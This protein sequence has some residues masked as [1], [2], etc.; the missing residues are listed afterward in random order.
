MQITNLMTNYKL[1]NINFKALD[2]KSEQNIRKDISH[3]DVKT[4]IAI[5]KLIE[6][7]NKN[8]Y[9]TIKL[10]SAKQG[11]NVYGEPVSYRTAMASSNL[12]ND[13]YITTINC[14]NPKGFSNL[15]MKIDYI[16]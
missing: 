6:K 2:S 8:Q 3:F 5:E 4:R 11:N 13:F 10:S 1:N 7:E 16:I 15:L 12:T 9:R 14:N